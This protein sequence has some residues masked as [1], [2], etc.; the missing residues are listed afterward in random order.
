MLSLADLEGL[1]SG[2][3]C[4]IDDEHHKIKPQDETSKE[5]VHLKLCK[6]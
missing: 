1:Y 6:H 2:R 3:G 4:F 5:K